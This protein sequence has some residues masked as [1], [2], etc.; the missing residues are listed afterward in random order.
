M[1]FDQQI[2]YFMNKDSSVGINFV[3]I[4]NRNIVAKYFSMNYTA[5]KDII[6]HKD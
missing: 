6:I 4:T 5:D 2:G 3:T 1:D